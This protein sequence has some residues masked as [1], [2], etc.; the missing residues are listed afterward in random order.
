MGEE[1][2]GEGRGVVSYI[3]CFLL[4]ADDSISYATV[5]NGRMTGE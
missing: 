4:I 5:S 1:R 3:I 2:R